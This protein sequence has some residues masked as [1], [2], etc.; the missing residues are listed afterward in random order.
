[1]IWTPYADSYIYVQGNIKL[2]VRINKSGAVKA[3]VIQSTLPAERNLA[4]MASF[5]QCSGHPAFTIPPDS[6][7]EVADIIIR[8]DASRSPGPLVSQQ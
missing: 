7:S 5:E 3:K 2:S 6:H 4:M 8:L 1:M